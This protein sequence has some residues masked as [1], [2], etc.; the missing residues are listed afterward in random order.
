MAINRQ[1]AILMA[2]DYVSDY[3]DGRL[4][5]VYQVS[6][7]NLYIEYSGKR[8]PI[9]FILEI[10]PARGVV[11]DLGQAPVARASSRGLRPTHST[12]RTQQ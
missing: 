10:D 11:N 1:E 2:S 9:R 3:K 7:D 4:S 8:L 12:E 6:G 5:D